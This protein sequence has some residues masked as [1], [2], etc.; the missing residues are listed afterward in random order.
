MAD[1]F[2]MADTWNEGATVFN[3]IQM[4]VT[5]IASA[6]GSA[7][8]N[9]LLNGMKKFEV[10]KNGE[11]QNYNTYTDASNY[12]RGYL[13]WGSNILTIGTQAAG[14]GTVRAV[15]IRGGTGTALDVTNAADTIHI[16]R[17]TTDVSSFRT[18]L[19]IGS[20]GNNPDVFM[21]RRAA[22]ILAFCANNSGSTG[23]A[24]EF[25]EQTAPAAPAADRVR[26]YAEDNGSGKTRLMA[27]F[28]TGAAQQIAIEP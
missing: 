2:D 6:A 1:I 5:D 20:N 18:Q 28:P 24:V 27:L 4:D 16:A 3:S 17:L 19:A 11:L 13:K 10:L 9:L 22:A 12:E 23:A 8:V 25:L 15:A 21:Y 26:I 14:T 7:F